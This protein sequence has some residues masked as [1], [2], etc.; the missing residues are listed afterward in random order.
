MNKRT[1]SLALRLLFGATCAAGLAGCSTLSS[2]GSRAA[3]A[4]SGA[5]SA[6]R[7]S[8]AGAPP[9]V[10]AP[11]GRRANDTAP[12]RQSAPVAPASELG[13]GTAQDATR[14]ASVTTTSPRAEAPRAAPTAP[15]A[16]PPPPTPAAV[17][18][19]PAP[20]AAPVAPVIAPSAR[21]PN[22]PPPAPAPS[23]T[24]NRPAVVAAAP[25]PAPVAR[26]A[27]PVPAPAAK[28]QPPV[29]KAASGPTPTK[30]P[31][32]A[33][34]RY[35][36]QIAAFAVNA[37]AEATRDRINSRLA[38]AGD[39]LQPSERVAQVMRIRDRSYVLV[40]DSADRAGAEA[41]AA[42]LRQVLNQDVAVMRR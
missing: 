30:V 16:A 21:A 39:Q 12:P 23:V 33:P 10:R 40:G 5:G 11:A 35:A 19:A 8:V 4:V 18:A 2:W 14:T 37:N 6:V 25:A 41:L 34:G 7:D 26:V 27:P 3:D 42:R 28:A 24:T 36:V 38:A 17:A 9:A 15:V 13:I 22:P 1:S 29:V 31:E 32:L 20:A